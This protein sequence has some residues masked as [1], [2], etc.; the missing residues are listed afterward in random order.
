M[1]LIDIGANT[2]LPNWNEFVVGVVMRVKC[3]GFVFDEIHPHRM[4]RANKNQS[5]AKNW[6]LSVWLIEIGRR[7][8]GV[9]L[10]LLVI[11]IWFD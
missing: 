11:F 4:Q 10:F 7:G 5:V 8:I 6:I 1:N 2:A 3:D 9:G